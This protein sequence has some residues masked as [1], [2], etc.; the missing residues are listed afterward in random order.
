MSRAIEAD[1]SAARSNTS[2]EGS[3]A[4]SIEAS[5]STDARSAATGSAIPTRVVHMFERL[6][7]ST[8]SPEPKTQAVHKEFH[9]GQAQA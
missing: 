2:V 7:A 8:D 4:T 1:S 5:A 9:C 3:A 6:R